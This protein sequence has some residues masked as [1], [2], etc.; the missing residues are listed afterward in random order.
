MRKE[1][2]GISSEEMS[3]H[4]YFMKH[5]LL[6]AISKLRNHVEFHVAT[7]GSYILRSIVH[8]VNME[9]RQG[10]LKRG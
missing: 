5:N 3:E 8:T 2:Q 7:R 10:V 6:H 1:A 4:I 9:I